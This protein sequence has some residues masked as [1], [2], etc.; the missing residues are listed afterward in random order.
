MRPVRRTPAGVLIAGLA[1]IGVTA[2]ILGACSAVGGAHGGSASASVEPVVG[3]VS[4]EASSSQASAVIHVVGEVKKA[5]LYA[6]P[7]GSRVSDAVA[8]AGGATK[9]ADL[10][11]VNLARTVTDGEQIRVPAKGETAAAATEDASTAPAV[12]NLNTA[13]QQQLETLPRVGPSMAQRILAYRQENGGFRSVDELRNVSGIGDKTFE[14]L[15]DF[16]SV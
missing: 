8:A 3:V 6:L 10:S 15:K 5:G 2:A 16:V 11:L 1:A 13:T 9:K 14:A 4:A 12:V 7:S